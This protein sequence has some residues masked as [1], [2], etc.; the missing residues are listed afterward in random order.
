MSCLSGISSLNKCSQLA[1]IN[2]LSLVLSEG[3]D[4]DDLNMLGNILATI[5]SVLMTFGSI[6]DKN[7][8][9]TEKEKI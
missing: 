7:E 5:G 4:N 9:K 2:S 3:L 8:E 6:S 1:L